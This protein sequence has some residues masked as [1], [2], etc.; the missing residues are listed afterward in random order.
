MMKAGCNVFFSSV[1]IA[2]LGVLLPA[3]RAWPSN[4]DGLATALNFTI[5]KHPSVTAKLEELNSLGY[6]INSAA[7]GRY[8]SLSVQAQ[9][10]RND[11]SQVI[12]RLQQ[13]LWAGGRI[14]GGINLAQLRLHA[15]QASLL[16]LRRQL[17]E[18]TAT[19]YAQLSGARQRLHAAELNVDEHEKLL[20]LISRRQA[21]SIASEADVRLARSRLTQAQALR[22]QLRGLV[23]K[24]LSDLL[25]LTQVPLEGLVAVEEEM[26]LLP[27][28]V[29]I[30]QE[31]EIVS[32][33]VQQRLIEVEV[34]REQ[35]NLRGS[36]MLPTLFAQ[37]ERDIVFANDN[38]NIPAE[39]RIGIALT[40]TVDG[41]GFAGFGRDK[42]AEALVD[43]ANWYFETARNE[44]R[45]RTRAFIS[46]RNMFL[47]LIESNYLL[48]ADT[49]ETLDS[50]MRQY[51][52]GR[53]SWVDVLNAQQELADARQ[54][55]EQTKS[56]LLEFSLRL[57][58]VIGRLD[59]YA[60]LL[61]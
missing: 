57:G 17:M 8:P 22:E 55:M 5:N 13:P 32:P 18:E 30:L 12:T 52:A 29:T 23:D 3:E 24:T 60:G 33:I 42:A 2:L 7:A 49:K 41:L 45:R 20:G 34:A 38:G 4:N 9:S 6:E 53:K 21:G 56:L 26:L 61:P 27:D 59:R 36:E 25:A 40:G 39:T 43:A 15:A 51:D 54:A 28:P 16:Q 47:R 58:V 35:A 44:V 19:T 37:I 14:T 1:L 46:D 50:F 48:V 11:Q 31:A 10:M